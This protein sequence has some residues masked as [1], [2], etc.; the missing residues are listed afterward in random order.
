MKI[1]LAQID[2]RL[3]DMAGIVERLEHQARLAHDEGARVLVAPSPL[4]SGILPGSMIEEA[5][6]EHDLLGALAALAARLNAL[7]M[8]GLVPAVVSYEHTPLFEVFMLKEGRVIPVRSLLAWRRGSAPD[9]W[10]PPVFDIDD[11]RVAVTFDVMRDI[12]EL[13]TGCDLL[14]FFQSN[15][16][17]MGNEVSSAVASVADGH[18]A[19]AVAEH[20]VWFACMAPVGGYEDVAFTGGSFVMDD[21][22]R[23]VAA[24]PCFEEALLVQ[25]VARGT[26]LPAIEPHRL[27]HFQREEWLWEALRLHLADTIGAAGLSRAVLALTGD[28]PSSLL[29]SLAVDALGP[30]NVVGVLIERDDVAT[31]AEEE[32]E[33]RRVGLV[34][35]LARGM[36]IRLVEHVAQDPVRALGPDCAGMDRED[37]LGR[38]GAIYLEDAA[39]AFE[40]APLSSLTK[41]DAALAAEAVWR[42]EAGVYAPFGDICLTE[43]EFL[44]RVRCRAGASIPASLVTLRAVRERLGRTIASGV[45]AFGRRHRFAREYLADMV[46]T[47]AALEPH[48]ID[49]AIEEHVERSLALDDLSLAARDPKAASLVMLLIHA[50]EAARR[51]LPAPLIVSARSF[52][53]RAWPASTAWMDSGRGGEAGA[54]CAELV[55][56]EARRFDELGEEHGERVRGEIIGVIAGMLGI[57]L[58]QIDPD[59]AENELLRHM[60]QAMEAGAAGAGR[61]R[62]MPPFAGGRGGVFFSQN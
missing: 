6:Y 36:G 55:E 26:T 44:A 12:D 23:V 3:G 56:R 41:T 40:A 54:S 60:Q 5:N 58:D 2:A 30:R 34:R 25:E 43:L 13:P 62:P 27:P 59:D 48:A 38:L 57:P 37:L 49:E 46:R 52:I 28:L 8:I 50:N 11:V 22:G 31:P 18:F 32:A 20:G 42:G 29:A 16:F 19:S 1:A 39:R 33:H 10:A 51:R 15:A 45:A 7:G 47:L 4:F 17:E 21:A 9:P 35:E 24:A 14:L 61:P 53:E